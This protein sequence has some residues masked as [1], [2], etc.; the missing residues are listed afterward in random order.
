MKRFWFLFIPGV[1]V[2]FLIFW[3]GSVAVHKTSTDEYCNSC[4]TIHPHA[5]TS[6]KKSVHYETK[7][8]NHTGCV[9]CHLPPKGE[10]Y[11]IAKVKQDPV[12]YG[13]NGPKIQNHST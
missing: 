6:W 11:L 7:S 10:G 2:G 9:E 4:H 1:F 8:G 3:S 12:I 13:E 5:T